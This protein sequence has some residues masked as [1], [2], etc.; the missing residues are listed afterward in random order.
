VRGGARLRWEEVTGRGGRRR[1]EREER[2]HVGREGERGRVSACRLIG[3]PDFRRFLDS[4][5]IF[6]CSAKI[7]VPQWP[8]TLN[9]RGGS[10][11]GIPCLAHHDTSFYLWKYLDVSSASIRASQVTNSRFQAWH[12]CRPASLHLPSLANC[13]SQSHPSLQAPHL[14]LLSSSSDRQ[15]GNKASNL[16]PTESLRLGHASSGDRVRSESHQALQYRGQLVLIRSGS[17][18]G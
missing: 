14:C 4:Y 1:G 2:R 7:L 16:A 6:A 8:K 15:H 5:M 13:E 12:Y 11:A 3:C 18:F 17:G 9:D 10:I